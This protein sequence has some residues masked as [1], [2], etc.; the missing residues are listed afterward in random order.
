[1]PGKREQTGADG[2]RRER[3]TLPPAPDRSRPLPPRIG[4]LLTHL[5]RVC[6]MPDYAAYVAHLRAHHPDR[7]IPTEREF[8]DEYVRTRYADGPTRCC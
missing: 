5:K 2:S 4:A 7:A 3:E 1:M 6:G 8:Y